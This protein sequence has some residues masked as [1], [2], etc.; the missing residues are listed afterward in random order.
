[1]LLLFVF[2][3]FLFFQQPQCHFCK[4]SP[5]L[6]RCFLIQFLLLL[7]AI[8]VI[9]GAGRLFR[10]AVQL[11]FQ[12]DLLHKCSEGIPLLIRHSP[13]SPDLLLLAGRGKSGPE[14]IW[15]ILSVHVGRTLV[16]LERIIFG[17]DSS[18]LPHIETTEFWRGISG[19]LTP[20]GV[21]QLLQQSD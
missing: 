13:V 16:E 3:L 4:I 7:F 14:D 2:A 8:R 21:S 12:I 18:G 1:M 17:E 11:F 9:K 15:G 6:L 19:N 10:S 20:D 5:D